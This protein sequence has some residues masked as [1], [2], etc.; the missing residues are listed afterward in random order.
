MAELDDLST[1]DAN[2]TGRFPENQAPSTLN[3]AGRALE[4][5]IARLLFDITGQNDATLSGSTI[6]LSCNRV[7]ITLTGTTSNY[8]ADLLMGFKI[9]SAVAQPAAL[10]IN[11]IG[12]ISLRNNDGTSLSANGIAAGSR[13]LCVKDGTTDYWRKLFPDTTSSAGGLLA[14][15]NLSDVSNASTSR[16]NLGLG[17]A[18]VKNTGTSGNAVPLLDAANTFSLIQV[19]SGG[20]NMT[21]A[22]TPATFA[23][24]Y[25][26]APLNTQ[27][28]T[29]TLVMSDAG[30]T[31]YHTSSSA[32]AWTIPPNSSVAF[33]LGTTIALLNIGSG[34]VTI[35]R[36]SGVALR[37][38]GDST[39]ANKTLAQW[40][41]CILFKYATD[42]WIAS[43]NI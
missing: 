33:P 12:R 2:N 39:D 32:H 1:T 35:T 17:T 10:N 19:F 38:A 22:T 3:N 15:N 37:E 43:G 41:Q 27:D 9:G 29:Y 36:G 23:V 18:A 20:L 28:A 7:S 16:T 8:R 21:P 11:G 4:G 5:M 13:V 34:A 24:G 42:S 30:K 6:Q 31:I 25:L 26:G 40:G 14:A